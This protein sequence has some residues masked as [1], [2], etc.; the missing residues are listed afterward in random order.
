MY[1]N[2]KLLEIL[3]LLFNHMFNMQFFLLK[4]IMLILI[5]YFKIMV[6]LSLF[7]INMKQRQIADQNYL[8]F[9]ISI[10][11]FNILYHNNHS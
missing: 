10:L 5:I 4:M 3:H 7:Y 6:I 1:T 8:N 11:D 9:I 2:V